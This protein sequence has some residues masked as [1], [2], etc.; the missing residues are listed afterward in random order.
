[1]RRSNGMTE[2][3]YENEY[4]YEYELPIGIETPPPKPLSIDTRPSKTLECHHAALALA[5]PNSR[6]ADS[7]IGRRRAPHAQRI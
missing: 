2:T 7:V 5:G 1:M 3:E 4:E 6:P